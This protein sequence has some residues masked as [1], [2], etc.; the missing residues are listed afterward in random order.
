MIDVVDIF[1]GP[2]GL[3]E[4]FSRYKV[5]GG[6][7]RFRLAVSIEKDDT[8]HKTLRL[9]ALH[10]L[11]GS[12]RAAYDG[13]LKGELDWEALREAYPRAAK[14]AEQEAHCIELGPSSVGA[15]RKLIDERTSVRR[16]WVLI[17]GPPCQA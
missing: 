3:G 6:D 8:A 15:V 14:A 4:G 11:I 1:A 17:G 7:A 12:D 2:G 9:R 16:P 5:K 10:R 13:Y